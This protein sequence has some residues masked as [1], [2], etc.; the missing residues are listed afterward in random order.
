MFKNVLRCV[1]RGCAYRLCLQVV[2]SGA[3][4]SMLKGVISEA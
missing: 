1:L 4:R 3:L 2:L